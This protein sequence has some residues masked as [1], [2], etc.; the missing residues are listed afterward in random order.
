MSKIK[1]G[2]NDLFIDLT[3]DNQIDFEM[4]KDW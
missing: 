2:L 1:S 4:L 3:L